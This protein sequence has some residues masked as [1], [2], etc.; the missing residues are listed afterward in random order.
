M[1]TV[2]AKVKEKNK[3]TLKKGASILP[4]IVGAMVLLAIILLIIDN[5]QFV[6]LAVLLIFFAFVLLIISLFLVVLKAVNNQNIMIKN[7]VDIVYQSYMKALNNEENQTYFFKTEQYDDTPWYLIPSYAK[8]DINYC[9]C[10]ENEEIRLYH[11]QAYTAAGQPPRRTIYLSGLY[12]I[13]KDIEGDMQYRDQ[14]SLSGMIIKSLQGV[15]GKDVHDVDQY[16]LKTKY[17]SGT[18]YS[19]S[20]EEVPEMIKSLISTLRKKTFV[21]RLGV[22]IKDGELHIAIE[23]KTIRL[24]YV[25]KYNEAELI[26]IKRV[27]SENVGLLNE[28][29][30]V[31]SIK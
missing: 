17:E 31:V 23:Q 24:P 14:E 22:A 4:K 29:K 15:Y 21:H 26:E 2:L 19:H 18:F 27:L 12:I 8:K 3:E 11:G 28:I 6:T 9:L 7:S 25:K 30:D 20:E 5:D 16:K 13:I 1:D 10:D